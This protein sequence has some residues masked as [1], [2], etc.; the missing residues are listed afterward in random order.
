M[1]LDI[2]DRVQLGAILPA[3]GDM[4]TL[5]IRQDIIE[6]TK[7]TQKEIKDW[8][9]KVEGQAMTWDKEKVKEINVDF[10]DAEKE[11]IKKQLK[12]MDG[13]KELTP[14]HISIY[15][16]FM[17]GDKD[18]KKKEEEKPEEPKGEKEPEPT[19]AETK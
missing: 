2:R 9:V 12:E 6:K 17:D 15:K 11:L 14:E 8:G 19:P 3:K 13:K 10:T 18:E 16:K 1:K 4:V 7:I 5:T